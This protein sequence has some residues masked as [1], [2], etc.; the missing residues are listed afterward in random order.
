MVMM[1]RFSERSARDWRRGWER[2][3]SFVASESERFAIPRLGVS[4][5]AI[6]Q[7]KLHEEYDETKIVNAFVVNAG[8]K[9]ASVVVIIEKK[10]KKEEEEG[11]RCRLK[12]NRS[13]SF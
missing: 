4:E 6:E 1:T 7:L 12:T 2:A 9:G 8:E 13:M 10:K 11:V 3:V 5:T